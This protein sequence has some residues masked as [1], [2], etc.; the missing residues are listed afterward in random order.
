MQLL[1]DNRSEQHEGLGEGFMA[2]ELSPWFHYTL[3][4]RTKHSA[5]RLDDQS[6]PKIDKW[7]QN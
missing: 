4:E 3:S 7:R 1:I 2:T 6:K 5:D